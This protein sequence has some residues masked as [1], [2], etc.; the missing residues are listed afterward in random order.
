M[1][2]NKRLH[3]TANAVIFSHAPENTDVIATLQRFSLCISDP[4]SVNLSQSHL[5]VATITTIVETLARQ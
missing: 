4:N 2:G 1:G 3:Q 5:L